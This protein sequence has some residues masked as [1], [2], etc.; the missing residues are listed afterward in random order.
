MDKQ[1][2]YVNVAS[3]EIHPDKSVSPYN[4]EIKATEEEVDQLYELLE[5]ADTSAYKSFFRANIPYVQYH[6]DVENDQYDD[7]LS[8]IYQKIHDLGNE[9][10]KSHIESMGILR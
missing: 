2:Y 5:M 1:S 10:T 6:Q 9:E 3:G 7:S 8:S 4:F